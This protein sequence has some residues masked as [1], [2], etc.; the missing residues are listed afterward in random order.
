MLAY[1]LVPDNPRSHQRDQFS[2]EG[3]EA[4]PGEPHDLT[5][6]EGLRLSREKKGQHHSTGLTKEHNR[7]RTIRNHYEYK[8]THKGFSWQQAAR[9][10]G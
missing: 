4:Y 8:R 7:S 3:A 6:V 9:I 1:S 10:G 2:L 5:K